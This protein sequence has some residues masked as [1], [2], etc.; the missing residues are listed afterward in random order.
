MAIDFPSSPTLNQQFTSGS[1]TWIWDGTSWDLYLGGNIVTS[2][3][4][5]SALSSYAP[6]DGPTISGTATFVNKP[7]MPGIQ[8]E[9]PYSSSSTGSPS[10]GDYYVNSSQNLMYVYV[11]SLV[12]WQPLGSVFVPEDD[13]NIL[14]NR[15]FG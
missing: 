1:T 13:Q 8:D 12:G 2:A 3:A 5:A 9:I 4:L 14:A 6:V 7:V 15:M 11:S 10:V